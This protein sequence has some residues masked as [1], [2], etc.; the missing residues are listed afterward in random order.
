MESNKNAVRSRVV[1]WQDPMLSAQQVLTMSGLEFLLGIQR[2]DIPRPPIMALMGIVGEEVEEG[3][4]VFSVEPAEY[5]YNPLGVVH[6]GLAATILD[7]A[8][9]CAVQTMLTAGIGLTTVEMKLNYLRPL[10]GK[11]GK[12]L[13]EGKVISVSRTLALAEGRLVDR[14]GKLYAHAT[15]TCMIL[16]PQ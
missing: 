5:H 6:G 15:E 12:V 3:R 9:A 11:T 7:T 13:C 10:T 16:R 14:Q 1:E 8:M 4:I 2:G